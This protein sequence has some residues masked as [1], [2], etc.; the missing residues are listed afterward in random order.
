LRREGV[1]YWLA[2]YLIVERIS[3]SSNPVE[4]QAVPVP[5]EDGGKE[6]LDPELK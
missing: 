2:V 3:C 5:E 6:A 4:V 1:F